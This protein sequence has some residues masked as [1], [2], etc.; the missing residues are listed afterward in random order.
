M[1]ALWTE[2]ASADVGYLDRAGCV[3]WEGG[4]AGCAVCCVA[5]GCVLI[6]TAGLEAVGLTAWPRRKGRL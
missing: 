3:A 2:S 1:H 6:L 4:R 5:L